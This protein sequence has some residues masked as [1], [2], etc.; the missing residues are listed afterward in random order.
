MKKTGRE[1]VME[2]KE[3]LEKALVL[4]KKID[5]AEY[6]FYEVLDDDKVGHK[7]CR[8]YELASEHMMMDCKRDI[9]VY[10]TTHFTEE[11]LDKEFDF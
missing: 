4:V 6:V 8:Y 9:D 11:D 10:I 3:D 2:V 1:L 7:I 5:D